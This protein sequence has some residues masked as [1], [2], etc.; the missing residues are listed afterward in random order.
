M[1]LQNLQLEMFSI[2]SW[3]SQIFFIFE[4]EDIHLEYIVKKT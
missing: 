4:L 2:L 3:N 1:K